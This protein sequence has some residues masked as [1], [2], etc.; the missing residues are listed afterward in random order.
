MD[1]QAENAVE[2]DIHNVPFSQS[3]RMPVSTQQYARKKEDEDLVSVKKSS[4]IAADSEILTKLYFRLLPVQVLLVAMGSINSLVDGVIAARCID[5]RTV[6]VVGLYYTVLRVL[7]A[8]GGVLLGGTAV[9]CGRYLG[10]GE[11][12]KTNGIFSLNLLVTFLAGAL[13]TLISFFATAPAADLLGAGPDLRDPLCLYILGYGMGIIPQLLAQQMASFL[14]LEQQ[15]RRCY[16]G[17]AVMILVNVGLDLLFVAQWKMGIFGLAVATSISNWAYFL[18]L[19]PFY[20][21]GRSQFRFRPADAPW[22]VLP[23]L[24][25]IGFPG[26]LLV[27]CLAARSLAVNRILLKYAGSDGLAAMTAF[28]M[29]SGLFIAVSLGSGFVVRMLTS[30]FIGEEDEDAVCTVFMIAFTRVLA[31]T[32]VIGAAVFVFSRP[33][34]G[35]YFTDPGLEVFSMTQLLFQIYSFVIHTVLL[36]TTWNNYYQAAGRKGFCN[37]LSVFDGFVSFVV[38]AALLAPVFGA[39]GVWIALPIGIVLTA[40]LC[41]LYPVFKNGRWPASKAE[42]L[43]LPQILPGPSSPAHSFSLHGMEDVTKT[44]EQVQRFCAEQGV[45]GKISFYSA[46]CLEEM[47]GNVIRHGFHADGKHHTANVHVMVRQEEVFLRIKDDCIPFNPGEYAEMVSG[48][49]GDGVF[50]NIGIRMVFRVASEVTYQNLVGL[51]VL[52]IRVGKQ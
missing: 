10:R 11:I 20:L 15:N 35:L 49:T 12:D 14:Q 4:E 29:I 42:W 36:C 43:L 34:T 33:L 13:L 46:L 22:R 44:A 24:A 25:A 48:R 51:N 16:C 2:G 17:I 18:V 3:V 38:P 31:L 32:L 52:T 47:A 50:R 45:P 26:A 39:A 37:F 6:G 41:F 9:L 27:V 19:V 8:I 1:F 23:E 28:N 40:A 5:A 21:R 7:E 30:I